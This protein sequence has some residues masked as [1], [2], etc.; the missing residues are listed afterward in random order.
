MQITAHSNSYTG[1]NHLC[2]DTGEAFFFTEI[3]DR[4]KADTSKMFHSSPNLGSYG[5][6]LIKVPAELQRYRILLIDTTTKQPLS[7]H[8]SLDTIPTTIGKHLAKD[9]QVS[10][11][12]LDHWSES[13]PNENNPPTINLS[14][15]AR[16]LGQD[17]YDPQTRTGIPTIQIKDSWHLV[18]EKDKRTKHDGVTIL[19]P[20]AANNF[21]FPIEKTNKPSDFRYLL[22]SENQQRPLSLHQSLH[23]TVA[24][25]ERHRFD[26]HTITLQTANGESVTI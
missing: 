19:A 5:E 15:P 9:H 13:N 16:F 6:P 14:T 21:L 11:A 18:G 3:A 25:A 22:F 8:Q 7:I 2:I 17:L 10:L 1:Q 20:A 24:F 4:R 12:K 26:G 23:S